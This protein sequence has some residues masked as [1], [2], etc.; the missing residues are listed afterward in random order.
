MLMIVV[1]TN[2]CEFRVR[3]PMWSRLESPGMPVFVLLRTKVILVV[4][5]VMTLQVITMI[6]LLFC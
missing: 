1:L 4:D 2:Y 5:V 3:I 6:L